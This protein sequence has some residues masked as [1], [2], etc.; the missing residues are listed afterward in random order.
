MANQQIESVL[1]YDG[2]SAP[3]IEVQEGSSAGSY[4][5]GDLVKFDTAGQI[6][7]ASNGIIAGIALMDATASAG[8][9]TDTQFME[10]INFNALYLMCSGSTSAQANVGETAAITFT[11]GA[12]TLADA[13]VAAG[14]VHIYGIYPGDLNVT[15]GRYIVRFST[16]DITLI[17]D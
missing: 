6:I 2:V 3:T 4:E 14:E 7:L 15:N 10:L 12:H 16:F 9:A 13:T 1:L 8:S 11:A 5:I 17:G